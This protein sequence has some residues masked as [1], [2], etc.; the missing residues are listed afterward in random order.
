MSLVQYPDCNYPGLTLIDFPAEVEG[1][2]VEDKE[3]FVLYPFIEL[4]KAEEFENT[5]IIAAGRF[6][7]K[8][9]GANRIELTKIWK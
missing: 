3:S 4:M 6:F 2:S 9:T 5:Q 8:L 1:K 7:D